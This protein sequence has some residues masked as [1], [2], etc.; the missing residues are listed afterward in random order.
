MFNLREAK[1]RIINLVLASKMDDLLTASSLTDEEKTYVR[2]LYGRLQVKNPAKYAQYLLKYKDEADIVELL[3]AFE[4]RFQRLE[5][6]DI[7][8]YSI[9]DLRRA[10]Q[11]AGEIKSEKEIKTEGARLVFENAKVKIYHILTPEASCLY[12]AGTKWCT[13]AER[14]NMFQHYHSGNNLYYI[15][16]KYR[17]PLDSKYKMALIITPSGE[18]TLYNARDL[19]IPVKNLEKEN[20][21]L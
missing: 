2:Q 9:E 19:T 10:L 12:G 18:K 13:A 17:K 6:K 7:Y 1:N 3:D 16:S 11:I 15:L 4:K 20:I 21:P 5:Q 14:S 8:K